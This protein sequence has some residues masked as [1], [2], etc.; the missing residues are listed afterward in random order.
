MSSVEGLKLLQGCTAISNLWRCF[1]GASEE[2]WPP[3]Y[4]LVVECMRRGLAKPGH[5]GG[6]PKDRETSREVLQ[7][8]FLSR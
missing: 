2:V 1:L 8:F 7:I 4:A 6:Y 5:S 3:V